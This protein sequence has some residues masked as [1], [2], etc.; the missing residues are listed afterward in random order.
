MFVLTHYYGFISTLWKDYKSALNRSRE[1]AWSI[2]LEVLPVQSFV[3]TSCLLGAILSS[4]SAES[5]SNRMGFAA[6]VIRSTYQ[7]SSMNA[8]A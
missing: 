4:R 5:S 2:L 6:W 7:P 1:L 8:F 3:D